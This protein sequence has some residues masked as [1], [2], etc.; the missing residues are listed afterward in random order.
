MPHLIN[1][2]LSVLMIIP[3]AKLSYRFVNHDSLKRLLISV[4]LN[5]PSIDYAIITIK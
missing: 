3:S 2:I 5:G 4:G 1:R